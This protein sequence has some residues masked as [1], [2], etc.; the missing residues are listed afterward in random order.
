MSARSVRGQWWTSV[1]T[2]GG[3]GHL[4]WAPGTWGSLVGLLLGVYCARA[5]RWPGLA[6]FLP[7][8]F[9]ICTMICTAAERLLG[10]HDPEA[11]I[12]DEVWGMVAVVIVARGWMIWSIPQLVLAFGLFRVFDIAKPPPLAQLARFPRGW[13][14]MADDLGAALYTLGILCLMR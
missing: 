9:I 5:I 1:A 14:I 4:P 13:G 2:I 3:V 12:L 6:A 10:Q 8:T 7:V 11:V